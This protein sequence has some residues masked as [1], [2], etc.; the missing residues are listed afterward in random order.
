MDHLSAHAYILAFRGSFF[1]L[2]LWVCGSWSACGL[3]DS[4]PSGDRSKGPRSPRGLAVTPSRRPPRVPIHYLLSLDRAV[5]RVLSPSHR[6]SEL[7]GKPRCSSLLFSPAL[8]ALFRSVLKKSHLCDLLE[9]S[10]A[11]A[12]HEEAVLIKYYNHIALCMT[13]E[14]RR[15]RQKYMQKRACPSLA[16]RMLVLFC[17]PKPSRHSLKIPANLFP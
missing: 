17:L 16:R 15:R 5:T 1:S 9:K 14:R 13:G 4:A 7:A 10:P 8:S 2:L 6:T 3:M 11:H 12:L